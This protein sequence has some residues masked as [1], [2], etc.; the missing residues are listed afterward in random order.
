MARFPRVLVLVACLIGGSVVRAG[1]SQTPATPAAPAD[2]VRVQLP[3]VD[4]LF[5]GRPD[6]PLVMIEYTDL[7][8][9]YCERFHLHTFGEIKTQYIDT[10][11][12]RFFSRDYP[13]EASHPLAGVAA[14]ADRCAADQK[15]F[16]EMRHAILAD[17]ALTEA[18]FAAIAASLHLDMPSFTLC[19]ADLTRHQSDIAKDHAEA[20]VVGVNGTGTPTFVLGKPHGAGVDGIRVVGAW[21]F[22]V[23]DAK[24]KAL[25][26]EK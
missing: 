21:G 7:Q 23:F 15:K 10:G 1:Q 16:W 18:S 13:V 26:A 2:D 17:P 6:A 25:L 24:L 9:P 4:G 20:V 12:L 14:R 3:V 11:K 22:D 19:T 8:C 5:L